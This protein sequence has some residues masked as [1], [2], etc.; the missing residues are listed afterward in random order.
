[1][2]IAIMGA[3]LSGLSC[4]LTLEKYGLSPII[5]EEKDDVGDRF[6][7]GAAMFSILSR[8]AVDS[9][10]FLS[11]NYN[12]FLQPTS[13]LRK[14]LFHSQNKHA[15]ITGNL[16]FINV[17]G[18]HPQSYEK[19]L[20]NQ[21]ESEI[22]FNS[23]YT[24]KQLTKD[25]TH[26][27]IATGDPSYTQMIQPFRKDLSYTIKGAIVNGKFNIQQLHSWL[28]NNF[29]PKGF[30]YLIPFNKEEANIAI[31]F[32]EYP[33]NQKKDINELWNR[34]FDSVC[35]TLNQDLKITD[36]FQVTDYIMGKCKAPR[37]G[38]TLFAGNCLCSFMPA[39][40]YGQFPSILTGVYAAYDLCG[41]KK[42]EKLTK[43]LFRSYNNSL[44]IRRYM[45]TLNNSNLDYLVKNINN[46]SVNTMLNYKH[47]NY[48]KLLSI[49]LRP[50]IKNTKWYK[51]TKKQY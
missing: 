6:I 43:K 49:L 9:I 22:I 25:F 27:I 21:V 1:M 8:P 30:S 44:I 51:H 28:D 15:S 18:R 35:N 20:A 31:G 13:N 48:P 37:I 7:N 40:G 42:Y 24:Y 36:D 14:I 32:P 12:I 19:Q 29:T 4:A 5:F 38:N 26:I 16:G 10:R 11:N 3:G 46:P 41:V 17:R 34:F 50:Y 47:F 45:E 23:S 39:F 2:K 33:T